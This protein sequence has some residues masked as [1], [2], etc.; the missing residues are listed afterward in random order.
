MD[1]VK[2]NAIVS[3]F[4]AVYNPMQVEM[5]M[6]QSWRG[7]EIWKGDNGSKDYIYTRYTDFGKPVAISDSGMPAGMFIRMV[8]YKTPF[9]SVSAFKEFCNENVK[10]M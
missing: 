4:S 3:S 8:F 2:L 7:F 6:V 10:D 5:H 9:T 1:T